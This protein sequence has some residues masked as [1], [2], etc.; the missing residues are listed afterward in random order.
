MRYKRNFPG[1]THHA[2]TA[3]SEAGWRVQ[4][5]FITVLD[6]GKL[7]APQTGRL[8]FEERE[9]GRSWPEGSVDS[10]LC[11]LYFIYI[12]LNITS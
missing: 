9:P 10:K 4:A 2:M 11:L 8:I 6:S 1:L 7:S 12:I 5:F 3:Y